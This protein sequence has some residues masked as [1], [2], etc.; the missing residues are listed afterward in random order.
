[1]GMRGYRGNKKA[2]LCFRCNR[3]AGD[4]TGSCEWADCFNPVPGWHALETKPGFYRVIGCPKF[5]TEEDEPGWATIRKLYRGEHLTVYGNASY[6]GPARKPDLVQD[7]AG[8]WKLADAIIIGAAKDY[9]AACNEERK[10]REKFSNISVYREQFMEPW[11]RWIHVDKPPEMVALER[12]FTSQYAEQITT[13]SP[14]YIMN[15]VREE[16]GIEPFYS[17]KF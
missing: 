12:F 10:L 9:K 6:P 2:S 3:A 11:R 1:M 15:K 13:G 4:L 16:Y 7:E 8:A 5:Q 14:I 17:L